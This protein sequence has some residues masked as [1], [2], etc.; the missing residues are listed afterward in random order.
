VSAID[1]TVAPL[2][3]RAYE[4]LAR[5]GFGPDVFNPTQH[6]ACELIERYATALAVDL[7]GSLGLSRL[8]GAAVSVEDVRA[9]QGWTPAITPAL[10]WL[11]ERL[12]QAGHLGRAGGGYHL[13]RALP[14]S[15]VTAIRGRALAVDA[16]F[17]PGYDLL[18]EA[19]AAFPAIARGETTGERALLGKLALWIRYF[20]NQ[21]GAYALNNRVATQAA[22]RHLAAGAHVLEVGAGLGSASEALLDA[23]A[24]GERLS[25]VAAY[26]A[27]EPVAFFSRRA[28]RVLTGRFPGVP[29]TFAP[30]DLNEPWEAQGVPPG[31]QQ[32]VWGVNVFHLAHDLDATL[33][34]A[35]AALAAG[36]ALVV[37]EGMRP[38]DDAAVGAELPFRLLESFTA[39]TCDPATRPTPGFLTAE[40]WVAALERAGFRDVAVVPD[41][42]ALRTYYA[43]MVA[44]AV[45]GVA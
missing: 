11:L 7:C 12:A 25:L 1:L 40:R 20:D 43:G 36:G 10:A 16:S 37:G 29:F 42:R 39:V 5:E 32:L 22:V 9:A 35:R 4:A 28:Q 26:R 27:T 44:A 34:R 3:A 18:D 24:A 15:S 6:E 31:S 13:R 30:L 23:L 17:A 21:N 8:L 14:D 38:A 19:A 45:V 41:V 2:D 33:R